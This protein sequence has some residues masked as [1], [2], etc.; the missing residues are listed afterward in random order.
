[1]RRDNLILVF[2][3]LM[4]FF[5]MFYITE[6]KDKR[7]LNTI[8]LKEKE[9]ENGINIIVDNYEIIANLIYKNEIDVPEV[10]KIMYNAFYAEK[11]EK[12][13]YRKKLEKKM[14]K[15]YKTLKEENIRQ[16]HFHFKNNESFLR[17]HRPENFGDDLTKIRGTV[18]LV[19]R[20]KIYFKGFEEGRI[21]NGYRYV[22]PI[23]Y[24]NEHIGS[25]EISV[26]ILFII[27]E[28]NKINGGYYTFI[29]DKNIVEKKVFEKEQS[30]YLKS[31]ISIEYLYD[32]KIVE[33]E[34]YK[35]IKKEKINKINKIIVPKI[36]MNLKQ[37]IKFEI[38]E[39]I[40]T[41]EYL[42][43]FIPIKNINGNVVAYI[44]KYEKVEGVY[45]RIKTYYQEI[46][47]L[48]FLMIIVVIFLLYRKNIELKLIQKNKKMEEIN[49]TKDKLFSIVSHD[50]K[51]PFMGIKGGIEL[52][53]ENFEEGTEFNNGKM[54]KEEVKELLFE[55]NMAIKN[56][57]KLLENLLEWARNQLNEIEYNPTEI[58]IENV[59]KNCIDNFKILLNQK[60]IKMNFENNVKRELYGDLNLF[61]TSLRNLITNAIKF[62]YDKGEINIIMNEEKEKAKII[63]KDFGVGLSEKD[64]LKLFELK[65]HFSK[66]GTNNEKGTG[67]GLLI[68]KEFVE[69]NGGEI[70][71]KSI[72]GEGS[73]FSF[74]IPLAP[75]K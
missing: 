45:E 6:R 11:N 60:N 44:I 62:S 53:K 37:K 4:Y 18:E 70:S 24:N 46:V 57:Y 27:K 17:M 39:K 9:M 23:F 20:K 58:K 5:S 42:V 14:K 54:E 28:L 26:S 38:L 10:K 67:L 68:V 1:M 63:V 65:S 50:L 33:T 71:C 25:V 72:L 7:I 36:E 59:L 15:L 31:D 30:N 55:L 69:R 74:T 64:I 41:E 19:N 34:E 47:M 73:E 43:L 49:K 52:L 21:F 3:L 35:N 8:K 40:R 12:D 51:S 61:Y 2:V 16:F 29:M 56:Y 13:K 48:T 32:K 75:K 22:F 66:L